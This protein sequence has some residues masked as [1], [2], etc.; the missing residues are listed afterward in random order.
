[1]F[2]NLNTQEG[3]PE[4]SNNDDILTEP[5]TFGD[6]QEEQSTYSKYTLQELHNLLDEAIQN[7]DYEKAAIIKEEIDKKES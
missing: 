7:E 5:E 1:M 4:D 2:L 3:N 6:D